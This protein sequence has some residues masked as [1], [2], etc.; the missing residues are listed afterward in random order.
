VLGA[1]GISQPASAQDAQPAAAN[2][3]QLAEV[4]VTGIRSSMESSQE[5]KKNADV[6]V[7]S[8]TAEDIG[9]LPDRSV[10]EA[11][12]RIPGVSISRFAGAN[13]PDHFSIEGTGVVVRGLNQVRSELNGRDTFSANSGRFLSFSDVPPELLYGVD[14]FKNQSADMIEGGL[15]GSVNLRTRVPFD[16]DGQL[17]GGSLEGN[18]GDFQEEFSP[19]GSILYSNRWET[20]AGDFGILANIVYSELTSRSD[21]IQVSSFKP[22][23]A[24]DFVP[25]ATSGT[26]YIPEGAAF[27]TQEYNRERT[28]GALALQWA[29]PNDTMLATLQFMRSD[30]KTAWAEHAVE[31]AT[32]NVGDSAF[33]R[34]PGT[35][36]FTFN[37]GGVFTSGVISA[38][39]G[40]RDDQ[41][42]GNN[43][44]PV[45]GL[46]SNNIARSVD[47]TYMTQDIGFNFKWTPN[48]KLAVTFDAQRI[49]S[50]VENLDMTIWGS[51]FQDASIDLTGDIPQVRFLPI[52]QV[53][54][55]PNC[56][57][58][59]QNCPLY[60]SGTHNSYAD[61]FNSFWRSAMD[62][63]EDS[64][65]VENAYKIDIEQKFGDGD[66]FIKSHKFGARF[67]D[68]DQTTRS[69]TYNWG[70]LSEI[71]GN[72]GPVWFDEPVDGVQGGTAGGPT[73]P[74]T[75]VFTFDN[76]MR[77]KAPVPTLVPFY[78]A[79]DLVGGGYDDLVAFASQIGNEW[80]TNDGTD[81]AWEALNDPRRPG[82]GG[83][84]QVDGYGG[85]YLPREINETS[86]QT[87]SLYYM[88]RWGADL[89]GDAS[90]SG[91]VGVRWVRTDFDATGTIASL[92]PAALLSEEDCFPAPPQ[93]APNN[94]FCTQ[95]TEDERDQAR[96]FA[97]NETTPVEAANEYENWL[98]S[99]NMKVQMT[100]DKLLRFGFSK[101]IAR[102]DLG[103]MRYYYLIEP[104][105]ANNNADWLGFQVRTGNPYLK[106]TESTQYDGSFEWYYAKA[107]SVTVSL[108]YKSL[109]NVLTN[110]I[111]SEEFT[112]GGETYTVRRPSPVNAKDRGKV[113]GV[114]LAYQQFF[115]F[116]PGFW[117]GFGVQANYT[118][119]DSNGV[120]QSVLS[121][122]GSTGVAEDEANVDTSK[123]PLVGLSRDNANLALIYEKGPV[124]ARAAYNWRSEY[125]LTTRDVITPFAPIM[126]EA[127]GQL[128]A[129]FFYSINDHLKIG[130]Q[131]VNLLDEVTKTSQVLNDQLLQ[132]GRSWFINDRRFSLG[133][134]ASF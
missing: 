121:S 43:R 125:L 46:Q 97:T 75:G 32:D 80:R 12:Q 21:G 28:G 128:D 69:T 14:V 13:D 124:S 50:T 59:S 88:I 119:I 72:G 19:T 22:R 83:A 131:G 24:A 23:A 120:K 81:N 35:P 130:I 68:R 105:T 95:L 9:A 85:R 74:S 122:G 111:T 110:E 79:T 31:I 77:G 1:I 5:I 39:T 52:N 55:T 61:P 104:Y 15:A 126:Q 62:H 108:F 8:V 42:N 30:A 117:G 86:E 41:F 11:L 107:G 27:R 102:P 58:P 20:G 48:E 17:I 76:F 29:N 10:T 91:N 7:D 47:Q 67:A 34:V 82:V 63:A 84:P 4:V 16:Q 18:Y 106:P 98:P 53:G 73:A 127:T 65:G 66:Q 71:W 90:I 49:D 70:V 94:G 118:Y 113:Q 132:A 114:E 103:L 2:E 56:T 25:G 3:T 92:S 96:R 78:N 45:N 6:F 40:W 36:E 37:D 51:T 99:F 93:Q 87:K 115:D 116:L 64:E 100:E 109:K 89:G 44:I 123:L 112:A 101:A 54:D 26:V 38:P 60:F 57:P 129:S 133:L 134:R 33:F